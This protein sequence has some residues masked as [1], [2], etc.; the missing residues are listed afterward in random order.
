VTRPETLC[1]SAG[2]AKIKTMLA[3]TIPTRFISLPAHSNPFAR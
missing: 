2:L 1:A 3:I